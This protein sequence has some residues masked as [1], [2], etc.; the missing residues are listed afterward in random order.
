MAP[1]AL[2]LTLVTAFV[3]A[4]V[5]PSARAGV[6]AGFDPVRNNRFLDFSTNT[7]NPTENPNFFLS[8]YDFSGVGWF[9]PG[10]TVGTG[11]HV[12]MIDDRH[13][14]GAAH[15][16]QIAP[17]ATLFFRSAGP[18]PTTLTRVVS[19]IQQVPNANNTSSDVLL[20]TLAVP[21][22]PAD[23]I[24]SYAIPSSL[25]TSTYN[26]QQ[27]FNYDQNGSLGRNNI[28]G[29]SI[30]GPSNGFAPYGTG[31][32]ANTG[33]TRYFIYDDD[34]GFNDDAFPGYVPPLDRDE[35]HVVG[36]DSGSPSFLPVGNTLQLVGSH[37]ALF[38]N[39]SNINISVDSF[40]PDY[41]DR[42]LALTVP[43]P[44]SLALIVG[45][46]VAFWARRRATRKVA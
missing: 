29:S 27:I 3:S 25:V 11:L 28:G 7:T 40:L 23:R 39:G 37:Y 19:S 13:F 12:T 21:F 16:A 4:I 45:A 15:V 35:F 30:L 14:I 46:S 2:R 1:F 41:R 17:G 43:E 44:S 22:T 9:T 5:A 26:N 8:A 31:N 36:G 20:G 42:I 34:T 38:S 6:I 10:L 32:F 33:N 24:A 18:N